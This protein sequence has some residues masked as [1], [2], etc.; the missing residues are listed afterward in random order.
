MDSLFGLA[1][2]WSTS[3]FFFFIARR[4]ALRLPQPSQIRQDAVLASIFSVF[5]AG[6]ATSVILLMTSFASAGSLPIPVQMMIVLWVGTF[7]ASFIAVKMA[8]AIKK[9][10]GPGF[11]GFLMAAII[12]IGTVMARAMSTGRIQF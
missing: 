8:A 3:S 10:S 7:I 4:L 12:L 11:Q 9:D 6:L 1:V 2:N 5:W